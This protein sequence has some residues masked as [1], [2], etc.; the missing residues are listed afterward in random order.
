MTSKKDNLAKK[1]GSRKMAACLA[2]QSFTELGPAQPQL[3]PYFF[4]SAGITTYYRS[5]F[6]LVLGICPTTDPLFMPV[7]GIGPNTEPIFC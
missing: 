5:Y 3:F 7:M 1:T 6:L 4:A 2:S